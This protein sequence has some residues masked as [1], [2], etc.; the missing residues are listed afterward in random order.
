MLWAVTN[1]L[2]EEN[3]GMNHELFRPCMS[4]LFKACQKLWLMNTAIREQEGSTSE[5]MLALAKQFS[6]YTIKQINSDPTSEHMA[7]VCT[8]II[9]QAENNLCKTKP[10]QDGVRQLLSRNPLSELSCSKENASS[11]TN[12]EEIHK[13]SVCKELKSEAEN[14]KCSRNGIIGSPLF[15][16]KKNNNKSPLKIVQKYGKSSQI[17]LRTLRSTPNKIDCNSSIIESRTPK[18]TPSKLI[19]KYT[20]LPST[21]TCVTRSMLA[22]MG[23][24]RTVVNSVSES[25][26]EKTPS[27]SNKKVTNTPKKSSRCSR[28]IFSDLDSNTVTDSSKINACTSNKKTPSK[29]S[30]QSTD[31]PKKTTRCTRN[32]FSDL[33]ANTVTNSSEINACRSSKKTPSKSSMQCIVTPEK[34]SQCARSIGS[35]LDANTVTDSSEMNPCS[36]KTPSKS[37]STFAD[38]PK[39]SSRCTRSIFSALDAKAVTDSLETNSCNKKTPSKSNINF[40]GTPKKSVRCTRSISTDMDTNSAETSSCVNKTLSNCPNSVS[41]S[42]YVTRSVSM[43]SELESSQKETPLKSILKSINSPC[44]TN[45]CSRRTSDSETNPTPDGSE[46]NTYRERTPSKSRIKFMCTPEISSCITRT[47]SF[48]LEVKNEGVELEKSS[49]NTLTPSKLIAQSKE[50]P[51]VSGRMIRSSLNEATTSAQ[52]PE[53]TNVQLEQISRKISFD[54]DAKMTADE[55][56]IRVSKET[57]NKLDIKQLGSSKRIIPT[58]RRMSCNTEIDNSVRINLLHRRTP[59]K[60]NNLRKG[61][62]SLLNRRARSLSCDIPGNINN[63]T[64]PVFLKPTPP[65]GSLKSKNSPRDQYDRKYYGTKS[66]STAFSDICVQDSINVSNELLPASP[67]FTS[68]ITRSRSGSIKMKTKTEDNAS[69][70]S[71]L[72]SIS[73]SDSASKSPESSSQINICLNHN[74]DESVHSEGT[75]K[76]SQNGAIDTLNTSPFIKCESE[77][78]LSQRT[79]S[80]YDET[81]LSS[82]ENNKESLDFTLVN[83]CNNETVKNS[84]SQKPLFSVENTPQSVEMASKNRMLHLYKLSNCGGENV[85]NINNVVLP[86][87]EP[88]TLVPHWEHVSESEETSSSLQS[89]PSLV[90]HWEQPSSGTSTSLPESI[91][92]HWQQL[93]NS[94]TVNT[95]DKIMFDLE[96]TSFEIT[97]PSTNEDSRASSTCVPFDFPHLVDD[98][99]SGFNVVFRK[100]SFDS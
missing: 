21:S 9:R 92:S 65:K 83:D 56:E 45:I 67:E 99:K 94:V 42:N 41:I 60:M 20:D 95:S 58:T 31:S 18:K 23:V 39:K 77:K 64:K 90:P 48:D 22:E 5:N 10:K 4:V 26:Q 52:T 43:I 76:C 71:T 91:M 97:F 11:P 51:I 24:N 80:S 66:D 8:N 29:C 84:S 30:I 55:S 57:S 19:S 27:K 68:P 78:S 7:L 62:T 1:A 82:C 17:T 86:D 28:I 54:M 93:T 100:N 96:D 37:N 50:S 15:K 36:K 88:P 59:P 98:S 61:L 35:D 49:T 38:T 81:T 75:D 69:I 16:M 63:V 14:S 85:D 2:R 70:D 25:S 32:I 87:N 46:T 6:V 44:R 12:C 79:N 34:A 47:M 33:D 73:N 3:M 89:P 13:S 72:V 40:I 74:T 53:K